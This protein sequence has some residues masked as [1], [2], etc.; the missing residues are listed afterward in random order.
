MKNSV[1]PCPAPEEPKSEPE[2]KPYHVV[3][4]PGTGGEPVEQNCTDYIGTVLVLP[5]EDRATLKCPATGSSNL[6]ALLQEAL[7]GAIPQG[8]EFASAFQFI[9][10]D[11]DQQVTLLPIGSSLSLAFKLPDGATPNDHY[12]ILYWDPTAKAG[13]GGWVE[14]PKYAER[15]DGVPL[16]YAL[17]PD[18]DPADGMRIFSGTRTLGDYV[19]ATVNFTGVFVLIKK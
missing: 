5:G 9:L 7:P 12:A 1:S 14:L 11:G 10:M 16:G 6:L 18:A 15:L 19:K 17:H 13:T 2:Q 4:V 8:T 3:D